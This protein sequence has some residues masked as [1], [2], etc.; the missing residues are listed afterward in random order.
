MLLG[1]G[2]SEEVLSWERHPASIEYMYAKC[3]QPIRKKSVYNVHDYDAQGHCDSDWHIAPSIH[4]I[5]RSD[6][7][8]S[9][10]WSD[11]REV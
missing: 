9:V 5:I 4:S 11:A 7:R 3:C 6:H 10:S 1:G 8:L 2:P